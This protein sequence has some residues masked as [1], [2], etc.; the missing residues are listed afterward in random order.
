MARPLR[1]EH[2]GGIWHLT[3]RGNERRSI[4]RCDRDRRIFLEILGDVVVRFRWVLHAYVLMSNHYH[5]VAETP[6]PNLSV[7]MKALNEAYASTFNVLHRRVGHLVQGRFKSIAVER[8]SHLLEVLRYVVLNPVRCQAVR[9]A[10]DY[11]WSNYRATAGLASGPSWL[12]T[13]WTLAQFGPG[14]RAE[15]TERYRQFVAD[16]KGADYKPWEH[17]VGQIYLGGEAFC[18]R[19]QRLVS[20]RVT[21]SEHP[22]PQ[23]VF[24]RPSFEAIIHLVGENFGLSEE[25]LRRRSHHPARKMLAQ[26]ASREAGLTL[27]AI[28]EWMQLTGRAVSHLVKKGLD[29]ECQ[30]PDY[31]R[32]L[33]SIRR[34]FRNEEDEAP[35]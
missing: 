1:P 30:N 5:L 4:Y 17:L 6:E 10:G 20:D 9:Y 7:G 33:D 32:R 25:E 28:G 24:V 27:S 35:F 18:D 22:K 21:E 29:L 14:S 23:R 15:L 26:L 16:G 2:A 11:P 31:R 34:S 8:E 13:E 19:M 12:N 3:S